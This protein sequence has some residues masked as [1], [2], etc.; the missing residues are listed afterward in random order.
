LRKVHSDQI[1]YQYKSCNRK[2]L[3]D[4]YNQKEEC[5]D[6]LIIKNGRITD[7]FYGNIALLSEN[8]WYTPKKPLLPGTMRQYLLEKNKLKTKDIFHFELIEYTKICI[9]NAMIPFGKIV[10]QIDKIY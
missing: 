7:T 1:D 8:Q 4:L 3:Q 2:K 5:D 10:L 9:F 6:I